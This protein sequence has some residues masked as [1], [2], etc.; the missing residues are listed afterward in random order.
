M[1]TCALCTNANTPY[2]STSTTSFSVQADNRTTAVIVM[3]LNDT[4]VLSLPGTNYSSDRMLQSLPASVLTLVLKR[5][6]WFLRRHHKKFGCFLSWTSPH[7][8]YSCVILLQKL[9]ILLRPY[10]QTSPL[11]QECRQS[12]VRSQSLSEGLSR[13]LRQGAHATYHKPCPASKPVIFV[14]YFCPLLTS[15]IAFVCLTFQ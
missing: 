8:T 11:H 15:L 14:L 4:F 7:D 12:F 6:Q 13:T 9:E 3:C 2:P 1:T 5:R 10:S